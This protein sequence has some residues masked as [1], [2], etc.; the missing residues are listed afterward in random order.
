MVNSISETVNFRPAGDPA[1]PRLAGRL[2][3]PAGGG[4]GRA[5]VL[6]HPDPR[7]GGTMD[8]WLLAAVSERLAEAGWV[9]LR[10]D[11]R[12]AGAS[13]GDLEQAMAADAA[14]ARA[15]LAGA[16]ALLRRTVVPLE[17]LAVVGWSF[18]ALLGLL[19]GPA[20]PDVTDWVGI[21]PVTRGLPDL[22]LPPV[23]VDRVRTWSAHRT[24]IVGDSDQFF[25]ADTVDVVAPHAVQVVTQADHF[26]FDRDDEVADLVAAALA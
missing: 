17:R 7:A 10:F 19:Q 15:D 8:V 3:T 6:V 18:G 24:V 12:G 9:V 13:A 20:E 16:F 21:A 22:P 1:G 2:R 25:P 11:V 26:L 5:A 14:G 4:T 23:P